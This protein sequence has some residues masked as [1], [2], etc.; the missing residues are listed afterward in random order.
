MKCHP[1][2]GIGP[3]PGGRWVQGEYGVGRTRQWVGRGRG[4]WPVAKG[5]D[6]CL[7]GL[8]P[9][10]RLPGGRFSF[11][12]TDLEVGPA[13]NTS[14]GV[15]VAGRGGR[16]TTGAPQVANSRIILIRF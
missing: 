10:A 2:D 15:V 13:R 6:C 1:Q 5:E 14:W 9:P 11:Q 3:P 16:S 12:L 8:K 7:G 4:S